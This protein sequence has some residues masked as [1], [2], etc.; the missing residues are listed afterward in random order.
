[1][2]ALLEVRDLDLYYGDAQALSGVSLEVPEGEIVAIVGS[3]GAGKS[4]LIRAIAGIERRARGHAF[5]LPG[6]TSPGLESHEICNLGIGQVAEGRQL[7]PSLT[8]LENL[9]MGAMLPRAR[10]QIEANARRSV[11]AVSAFGRA[12]ETTRRHTV[13][14]RTADARHRPLLDGPPGT[15]DARRALARPGAE[16]RAATASHDSATQSERPD[17]S[18]W[19][20]RTSPSR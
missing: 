19:S 10:G 16:P 7:F 17:D 9:Q 2:S 3:N 1:M 5:I 15:D 20:S 13:R 8:T 11:R 4:T 14:R 18:C 12:P 6:A